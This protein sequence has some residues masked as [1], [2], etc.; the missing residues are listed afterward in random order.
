[1]NRA[2]SR[3]NRAPRDDFGTFRFRWRH[4]IFTVRWRL[5]NFLAA[6]S[7]KAAPTGPAKDLLKALYREYSARILHEIRYAQVMSARPFCPPGK[8]SREGEHA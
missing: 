1:M 3:P 7:L 8:G 5:A 6:L 2:A 4:R